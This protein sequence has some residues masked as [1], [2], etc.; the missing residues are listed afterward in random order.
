MNYTFITW[1]K[2]PDPLELQQVC[3][4]VLERSKFKDTRLFFVYADSDSFQIVLCIS[5]EPISQDVASILWG[6]AHGEELICR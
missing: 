5:D 4:G 2:T 1:D 3:S 6:E